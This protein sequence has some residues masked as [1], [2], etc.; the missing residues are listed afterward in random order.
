MALD[1]PFSSTFRHIPTPDYLDCQF[2]ALTK[3]QPDTECSQPDINSIINRAAAHAHAFGEEITKRRLKFTSDLVFFKI[4]FTSHLSF[5]II[6]RRTRRN[7]SEHTVM[8]THDEIQGYLKRDLETLRELQAK[9]RRD[10]CAD[11]TFINANTKRKAYVLC[12][13]PAEFEGS[14][15]GAVVVSKISLSC[16]RN[17][18]RVMGN[19]DRCPT[20]RDRLI[21]A[22]LR[23][24][25]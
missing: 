4:K 16:I 10:A 11:W 14:E 18:H 8:P 25:H 24:L 23:E 20:R 6:K 5:L 19:V 1:I 9:I 3:R 2:E 7:R 15:K 22:D 17:S 13:V 12:F 21:V